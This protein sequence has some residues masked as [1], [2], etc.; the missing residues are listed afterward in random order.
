MS[1]GVN[2]WRYRWMGTFPNQRIAPDAGAWHGSEIPHV[3]GTIANNSQTVKATSDQL[4]VSEL[5]NKAWATF[6]KDPESGLLK[7][8]WPLYNEKGMYM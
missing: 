3:F 7:L 4:K 8:G 2:A 6:A 1:K 5:M